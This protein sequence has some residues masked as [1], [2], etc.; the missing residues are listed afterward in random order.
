MNACAGN[1][2]VCKTIV[3]ALASLPSQEI[4]LAFSGVE[5]QNDRG[6]LG[7]QERD[8]SEMHDEGSYD[9][10]ITHRAMAM[11]IAQVPSGTRCVSPLTPESVSRSR[12]T[13]HA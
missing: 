4:A 2:P 1:K 3:H 6:I 8:F 10:S 5:F 12:P 11:G 9:T 7:C 13:S